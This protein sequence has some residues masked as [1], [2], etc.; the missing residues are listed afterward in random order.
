MSGFV[1]KPKSTKKLV[2]KK[3][4]TSAKKIVASNPPADRGPLY[5]STPRNPDRV[6]EP[7]PDSVSLGLEPLNW[8]QSA[9]SPKTKTSKKPSTDM[10]TASHMD[11]QPVVEAQTSSSNTNNQMGDLVQLTSWL[12]GASNDPPC[13]MTEQSGSACEL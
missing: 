12:R 11:P 7:F 1:K 9:I 5:S 13:N 2:E 3:K 6:V 10:D 4:S 8:E